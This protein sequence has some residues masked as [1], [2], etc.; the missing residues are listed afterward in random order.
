VEATL[1]GIQVQF[2]LAVRE[3]IANVTIDERGHPG[4]LAAYRRCF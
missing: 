1:S 3:R 4:Q 2:R